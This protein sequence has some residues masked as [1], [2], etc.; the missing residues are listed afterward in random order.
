MKL[1]TYPSNIKVF[2]SLVCHPLIKETQP[3]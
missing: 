1:F 2:T 3:N